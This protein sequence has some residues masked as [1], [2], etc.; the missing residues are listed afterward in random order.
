MGKQPQNQKRH[1]EKTY[2][3]AI[4]VKIGR[5]VVESEVDLPGTRSQ[6][7]RVPEDTDLGTT[8]AIIEEQ[9]DITKCALKK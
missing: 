6:C 5:L 4:L 2:K 9:G 7:H 1:K 8:V 3:N